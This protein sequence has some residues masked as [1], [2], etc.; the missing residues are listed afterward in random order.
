MSPLCIDMLRTGIRIPPNTLEPGARYRLRLHALHTVAQQGYSDFEILVNLA[1]YNGSCQITPNQGE[2]FSYFCFVLVFIY[3]SIYS[4]IRLF[5]C[6]Y[7]DVIVLANCWTSL[8]CPFF[9]HVSIHPISICYF[10]SACLSSSVSGIPFYF[11][12]CCNVDVVCIDLIS[13][14][15]VLSFTCI[16]C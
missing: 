7:C 3:L 16:L 8:L 12:F 1:P 15:F 6:G 5:C 10:R 13:C 11:P 14:V 9:C 4:S 2:C